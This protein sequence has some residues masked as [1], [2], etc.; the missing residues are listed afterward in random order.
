MKAKQQVLKVLKIAEIKELWGKKVEEYLENE[1]VAFNNFRTALS[2]LSAQNTKF[3]VSIEELINTQPFVS[4]DGELSNLETSKVLDDTSLSGGSLKTGRAQTQ[5]R[6]IIFIVCKEELINAFYDSSSMS[7]FSWKSLPVEEISSRLSEAIAKSPVFKN[8]NYGSAL[9]L[10]D[11]KTAFKEKI[12]ES[13]VKI[14]K[15]KEDID[16]FRE[17]L[18]ERKKNIEGSIP[19]SDELDELK[20]INNM[21]KKYQPTQSVSRISSVASSIYSLSSLSGLKDIVG[22]I[23]EQAIELFNSIKSSITNGY[24]TEI[25]TTTPKEEIGDEIKY[26]ENPLLKKKDDTLVKKEQ[27]DESELRKG[28]YYSDWRSAVTDGIQSEGQGK[29]KGPI[30]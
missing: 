28:G 26:T 14:I 5:L 20:E 29:G 16:N 2:D 15:S 7:K 3:D 9:F 21:L 17:L 19:N 25:E 10:E 22:K 27:P 13:G 11:L 4:K 8:L 23:Y 24:S 18:I 6:E 30:L 1:I 12:V